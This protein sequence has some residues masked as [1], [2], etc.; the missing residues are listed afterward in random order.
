MFFSKHLLESDSQ[1]EPRS[2]AVADSSQRESRLSTVPPKVFFSL[3]R[4]YLIDQEQW[5]IFGLFYSIN[6]R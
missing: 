3:L 1:K 4:G 2:Q 5:R 6:T